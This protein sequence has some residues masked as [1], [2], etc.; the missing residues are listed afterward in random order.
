M[1]I[2]DKIFTHKEEINEQPVETPI[3]I[4]KK[5]DCILSILENLSFMNK[6]EIRQRIS[7]KEYFD[8]SI[9][10]KLNINSPE[11]LEYLR[12]YFGKAK[13]GYGSVKLNQIRKKLE[14]IASEKSLEGVP[15]TNILNGIITLIDQEILEYAN[16]LSKFDNALK[17]AEE[18]TNSYTEIIDKVENLKKQFKEQ[19]LGYPVPLD[20]KVTEMVKEL[21]ELPYGGY[22]QAEIK[23]FIDAAKKMIEE[24]R[25]IEADTTQTLDRINSEL[26]IPR[27]NRYLQDVENLKRKLQMIDESPYISEFEKEQNKHTVI[28]EFNVMNG[29]NE[30]VGGN[31]EQLKKNL[32]LLEYGGYGEEIINQFSKRAETMISDGKRIRKPEDEVRKD[33][34]ADYQRLIENYQTHLQ[35]MKEKVASVDK[36]NLTMQEKDK[37]KA[38]LLED[39]HDEMGLP[40]DYKERLNSMIL[41][42]KKLDR[43]GYGDLKI[44]EFKRKSLDR[45]KD[46]NTRVEIR[47]ALK[48]IRE[49]Q[50][51]LIKEYKEELRKLYDASERISHDRHLSED[52][53]QRAIEEFDRDFKFKVGYRM[54]FA[55][56]IDNRAE[57]LATLPG[58][59]YGKEA[60]DEFREKVQII[61]EC[62][63]DE[64]EKYDKIRTQFNILR[65][66]YNMNYKTF[67]EWKRLKL[68]EV[69]END[70]E[71]L[72]KELNVKIAYMLSLSPKALND[73]YLE[74]DRRRKEQVDKH[75]Y[76]VVF[77]HLAKEEA[78]A[79]GDEELYQERLNDLQNGV[80]RYSKEEIEE[81]TQELKIL[82]LTSDDLEDDERL[83]SLVEYIDSTLL[84]QMMYIEARLVKEHEI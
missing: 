30:E 54:N 8:Q 84:R 42:L 83:I 72:E 63:P 65:K 24:G 49:F 32:S 44:D 38:I 58:G 20:T 23:N 15:S 13:F 27:K 29:H 17:E 61:T 80:D 43:G 28:K 81:A 67:K 2:F 19:E 66:Q 45:L 79:S 18:S 78:K 34:I 51:H 48:E 4:T 53:K 39:F 76:E 11:N 3:E 57:E 68:L 10:D 1:G 37:K 12:K 35:R 74:D 22:G 6:D 33:I 75:N 73:Y 56:Y 25:I 71:N 16:I 62:T 7:D 52:E 41:E 59:G 14:A 69:S 9:L 55:K 70:R 26:F 77:K 5:I 46:V 50:E 60:I 64:K 36:S 21:Q 31:L 40:I 82:S 47:D